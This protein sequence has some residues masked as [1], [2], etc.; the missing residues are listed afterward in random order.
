MKKKKYLYVKN[1]RIE[2][3][4]GIYKEFNKL[5]CKQK[6]SRRKYL[7]HTIPLK[8]DVDRKMHLEDEVV[9]K[10]LIEKLN[11]ILKQLEEE[12]YQLI[13]ELF[14]NGKSERGLAGE[15]DMH[16]MTIHNRKNRVLEKLKTLMEK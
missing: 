2:I 3:S 7:K 13:F 14:F 10:I 11:H 16:H 9:E 8:I 12:E 15:W 6:Y 1:K 4:S 5:V